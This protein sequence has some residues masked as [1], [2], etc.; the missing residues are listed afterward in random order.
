MAHFYKH[1]KTGN[2]YFTVGSALHT[3][4]NDNLTLYKRC[5]E[6][7]IYARPNDMFFDTVS[8][9]ETLVKRFE[10]I[11]PKFYKSKNNGLLW[12]MIKEEKQINTLCMWPSNRIYMVFA[13]SFKDEF[14]EVDN[15]EYCS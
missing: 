12:L 9:N 7:K 14:Y 11:Y 2:I 3:E 13:D 5:G 6:D 15:Y 8:I 4:T 10:R 1:S